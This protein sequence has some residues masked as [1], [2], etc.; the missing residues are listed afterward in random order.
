MID[1]IPP[2]LP[3]EV[4]AVLHQEAKESVTSLTRVRKFA[5]LFLKYSNF[6]A[7]VQGEDSNDEIFADF[8]LQQAEWFVQQTDEVIE[9]FQSWRATLCRF[10]PQL[11]TKGLRQV[12]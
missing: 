7:K 1:A 12:H 6:M 10:Y 11:K 2:D 9:A 3:P 5:D 8:D 4:I